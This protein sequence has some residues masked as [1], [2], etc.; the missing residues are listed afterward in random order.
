MPLARVMGDLVLLPNGNILII[1]SAGASTTNWTM[2]C[3]PVLT[4]LIYRHPVVVLTGHVAS[5]GGA[6]YRV[7]VSMTGSKILAPPGYYLMFVVYQEV[8]SLG[9]WVQIS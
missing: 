8:P 7:V 2:A 6:N 5:L 3:Y 1:N 4:P 9:I